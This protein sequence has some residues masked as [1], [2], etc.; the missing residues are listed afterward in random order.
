MLSA[1]VSAFSMR[2]AV[3]AGG[4]A[5]TLAWANDDSRPY[6]AYES[7]SFT[8]FLVPITDPSISPDQ[9]QYSNNGGASWT[10]F[11]GA[12]ASIVTV[13][14]P[15]VF[16]GVTYNHYAN[17]PN[18]TTGNPSYIHRFGGGAFFGGATSLGEVIARGN[19][20]GNYPE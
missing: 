4:G 18:W 11:A 6:I 1:N 2:K 8:I 17:S 15:F 13:S 7:G 19:N 16:N 3:G 5:T 12:G 14:T 9:W 10:N 20:A